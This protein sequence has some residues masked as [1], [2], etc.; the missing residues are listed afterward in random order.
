[1]IN[2]PEKCYYN[3][4]TKHFFWTKKEIGQ[5]INCDHLE[6]Y[7]KYDGLENFIERLEKAEEEIRRLKKIIK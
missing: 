6:R 5:M 4:M 1:M 7:P 3:N 2:P